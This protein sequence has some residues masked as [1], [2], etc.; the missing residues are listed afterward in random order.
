[1][2]PRRQRGQ[3]PELHVPTTHFPG[4]PKGLFEQCGFGS[5]A[6]GEDSAPVQIRKR[7]ELMPSKQGTHTFAQAPA[8]ERWAAECPSTKVSHSRGGSTKRSIFIAAF[9]TA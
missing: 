3:L 1:M 7:D 8:W 6:V 5:G 4:N 9:A 2:L